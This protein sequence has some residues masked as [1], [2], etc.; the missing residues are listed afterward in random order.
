MLVTI[1]LERFS[2]SLR[3]VIR[4]SLE[5]IGRRWLENQCGIYG[6]GEN[7]LGIWLDLANAN[8]ISEASVIAQVHVYADYSRSMVDMWNWPYVNRV[9]A[10]HADFSTSEQVE[11][12]L[13]DNLAKGFLSVI[14]WANKGNIR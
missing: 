5:Q 11:R 10:Y 12:I 7:E 6:I 8:E 4:A 13:Q 9:E 1:K 3:N 2:D 14:I